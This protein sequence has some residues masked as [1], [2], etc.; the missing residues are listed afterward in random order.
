MSSYAGN[1]G[2][3]TGASQ[4]LGLE[5]RPNFADD[6]DAAMSGNRTPELIADIERIREHV[7][8]ERWPLVLGGSWGSTLAIA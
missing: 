7:G 1:T 6:F 5:S 2:V 8:I 4:G 3:I